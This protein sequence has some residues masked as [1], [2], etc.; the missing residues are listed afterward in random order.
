MTGHHH[1]RDV[2]TTEVVS[3]SRLT[4]FKELAAVFSHRR[5]NAVPV[6][7]N[8]GRVVGVVSQADLLPKQVL[9]GH[10]PTRREQL[11]H[12]EEIEKADATVAG[13]LMTAPAVTVDPEAGLGAAARLMAQHRVKQLP[14][15]GRDGLPVGVV[16]RGDLLK[17]FLREDD[18]LSAEVRHE[19]LEHVPGIDARS[20]GITVAEGVVAL[21]GRVEDAAVIPVVARLA[22]GIEGVVAVECRLRA[23]SE[24]RSG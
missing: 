13:D 9:G 16:S 15:V 14:V 8:R 17:V 24:H 3:V 2:M 10:R 12:L 22:A 23:A 7:D 5:I 1:V 18:Q 21:D 19:L 20:I 6:L 4:P 11:L